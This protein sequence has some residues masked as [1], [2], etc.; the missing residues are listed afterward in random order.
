[1]NPETWLASARTGGLP[2]P[3][4]DRWQPLRVGVV[5]L[6]EYDDAEFWYADGRLVLRGGNGAG[7]TK[8]LELTTLMLLRGEILPSVLDPFGSQHRTMKFNLL[9][10]GE[11]DDPRPMADSGLGYA[12]AEYGRLDGDDRP[13]YLVCGMGASARRGSGTEKVKRWM[14]VTARRP[15]A[16]LVLA[17]AAGPLQE[18]ELR[19]ERGVRVY[20]SGETYRAVLGAELFGLDKAGYDNLTELLKQLRRPKLGERLNPRE[21]ESTLRDALPRL[22]AEEVEQLVEG[23]DRLEEL[24]ESVERLEGAA[25]EVARFNRRAWKPWARLVVR[26]RSDELAAA[27]TRFDRTTRE[28]RKAENQLETVQR[29]VGTTGGEHDRTKKNLA[30]KRT[31]LLQFVESSAYQDAVTATAKAESLAREAGQKQRAA[32]KA[33]GT[34]A[35]KARRLGEREAELAE[36]RAKHDK[37]EET[38]GKR[39]G[40]VSAVAGRAGLDIT[41]LVTARDLNGVFAA[42]GAR[43]ERLGHLTGLHNTWQAAERRAEESARIL[44][45]REKAVRTIT[46][47]TEEATRRVQSMSDALAEA[48]T[49]W[50]ARL[51]VAPCTDRQLG[52]WHAVIP[53]VASSR[54]PR[55]SDALRL[56]LDETAT[57]L[58]DDRATLKADG[59]R[60]EQVRDDVERRLELIRGDVEQPPDSPVLW[61]RRERPAVGGAPFWACVRPR[62]GAGLDGEPLARLEAALAASGI[63]D[64]WL[65]PDGTLVNASETVVTAGPPM[66]HNLLAAL[67][68]TPAQDVPHDRIAAVLGG[69]GWYPARPDEPADPWL[70]AD[71]HWRVGALTGFAEPVQPASYLGATARRQARERAI[72]RLETE[73]AGHQREIE[74]I[75]GA[76]GEIDAALSRLAKEAWPPEPER[77]LIESVFNAEALQKQ[78]DQAENDHTL[79]EDSHRARTTERDQARA[80]AATYAA[81]HGFPLDGL[82]TVRKALDDLRG[83]IVR[84]EAD[85][86]LL[87]ER[88][89]QVEKA[90]AEHR[91]AEEE[92]E[93]ARAEA[94]EASA[95]A[96]KAAIAAETAREILT[97]GHREQLRRRDDLESAVNA[98]EADV[99]RLDEELGSLKLRELEARNVLERHEEQR[100]TAERGR[101]QAVAA[102]WQAVDLGLAESLGV[103]VPEN[104]GVDATVASARA[105]RRDIDPGTADAAAEERAWR[106]CFEQLQLLRQQLLTKRDAKVWEDDD[107]DLPR[108]VV[109]ADPAEGWVPPDEAERTLGRQVTD[110]QN[111]FNAEQQ[112]VL[113]K[114]LGSAFI[115]HLK[116]RLDY[117]E[118][119]FTRINACLAKHTTRQGHA[120]QLVWRADPEDPEAGRVVEALRQG[121]EHLAPALQDMVRDFL[122]R[123]IEAARD[124]AAEKGLAEWKDHLALA[125][126]YRRWIRIK[127]EFKAGPGGRWRPFDAARHGAKSGGEKVVL[128]S[129]PLFAAAV[130]AYDAAGHA[131][132]RQ[133]WLDEAMT[134]VDDEV[135][136]RFMGLIVE[137]DLDVMLTA[138]DE[139]CRYATVPAVAVYD[140]ARHRHLPGVDA[141]PHLWC[142]GEWALLEETRSARPLTADP[143]A[144]EGTLFA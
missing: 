26:R 30:G 25:T 119:V 69:I 68:P 14:F 50:A 37:A 53:A 88:Q 80:D 129:Q 103:D 136:A 75:A 74:K 38:T 111:R 132:P 127:V 87:R 86:R 27:V 11:E 19:K 54:T 23:W 105:V 8:L 109:L 73:L 22:A 7:K 20:D 43:T 97:T 24:R 91:R 56:H 134:G 70:T 13:H 1:M 10:T 12:W 21:L 2:E 81:D 72:R 42:H 49:G 133:I 44:E 124:E 120:L 35:E 16:D 39:G 101:D 51:R 99:D 5:N 131:A 140:L 116:D 102:W 32:D 71:G 130:V 79:A 17:P 112:R 141:L 15:G 6:W 82:E 45:V 64:A 96:Y 107:G 57:R 93:Q 114:L 76:I 138:H 78:L 84:F 94:E 60:L 77:D 4:R 118:S 59:D 98:L 34:A 31:E 3:G 110:L 65:T 63:L 135:K 18:K 33:Q 121:Y 122:R 95:A 139:W 128:L 55:L 83:E 90:E 104:R 115:E 62:D 125:L 66:E 100:A 52:S 58:R 89:E 137:L 36:A 85:L 28:R 29:E 143:L 67:E 126:D 61:A 92:A 40:L 9:P 117:T 113:T 47:D 106:R 48:L 142:G 108:V 144:E 46:A 123:K 41:E